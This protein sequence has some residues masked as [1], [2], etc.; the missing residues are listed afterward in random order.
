LA[1]FGSEAGGSLEGNGP[2]HRIGSTPFPFGRIVCCSIFLV[3][4]AAGRTVGSG[5]PRLGPGCRSLR[6]HFRWFAA[7]F[8]QLLSP[9][10]LRF[11]PVGV[12][13]QALSVPADGA[14]CR[15][16]SMPRHK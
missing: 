11:P 2:V 13:S 14:L 15:P 16:L 3:S 7:D 10:L 8:P 1:G 5:F 9:V 12:P 6:H 4:P